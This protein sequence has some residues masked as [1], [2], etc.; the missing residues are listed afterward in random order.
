M[1]QLQHGRF[2]L[3]EAAAIQRVAERPYGGHSDA[4]GTA[5]RITHDEVDVSLPDPG[6]LGQFLVRHRRL[7][8]RLRSHPP[9]LGEN[10]ELAAAGCA[11][12][13]TDEHVVT[14]VDV[15]LP[16]RQLLLADLVSTE[17]DLQLGSV[18]LTERGEAELAG[19]AQEDHPTGDADLLTGG[20]VRRQVRVG[21]ADLPQRVGAGNL[22]RVGVNTGIEHP[23]ALGPA[24]PQLLREIVRCPGRQAAVRLRQLVRHA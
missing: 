14:E 5:R 10:G 6:L 2:D 12:L 22:H 19:V 15:G 8:Q 4:R 18:T 1:H 21:V 7:S 9:F 24:H 23:V 17:H 13:T 11:D 20:G 16:R 3:D